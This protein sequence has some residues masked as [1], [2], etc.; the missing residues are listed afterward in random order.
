M[1]SL[2]GDFDVDDLRK[3]VAV[4]A[5]LKGQRVDDLLREVVRETWRWATSDLDGGRSEEAPDHVIDLIITNAATKKS[6]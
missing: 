4:I 5:E 2:D 3:I 1:H 6:A